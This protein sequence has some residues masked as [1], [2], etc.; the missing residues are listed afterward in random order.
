MILGS[1]FGS[2][3]LENDGGHISEMGTLFLTG[4]RC[5]NGKN[6]DPIQGTSFPCLGHLYK[7]INGSGEQNEIKTYWYSSFGHPRT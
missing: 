7:Q 4:F 3:R 2:I 6:C 5:S 1:R